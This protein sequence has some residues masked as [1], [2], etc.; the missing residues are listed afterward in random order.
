MESKRTISLEIPEEVLRSLYDFLDR[1][2]LD[3]AMSVLSMERSNVRFSEPECEIKAQMI[4]D[5]YLNE[6]RM[7]FGR[8]LP[9][10]NR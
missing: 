9:N 2:D 8:Q 4:F 10:S 3:T 7:I 6:L 1:L 5:L